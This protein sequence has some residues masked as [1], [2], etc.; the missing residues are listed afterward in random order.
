M[1]GRLLGKN[2][3]SFLSFQVYFL[4]PQPAPSH[5]MSALRQ[6]VAVHSPY[7]SQ[8]CFFPPVSNPSPLRSHSVSV[9][10]PPSRVD[11]I[12]DPLPPTPRPF[13]VVYVSLWSIFTAVSSQM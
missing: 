1:N 3:D 7:M 2:D 11:Y 4:S 6:D 13:I 8:L 5:Y 12:S 10:P 9:N